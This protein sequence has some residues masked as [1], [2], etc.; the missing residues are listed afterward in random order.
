MFRRFSDLLHAKN[1]ETTRWVSTISAT[2]IFSGTAASLTL[3]AGVLISRTLPLEDV[4]KYGLLLS[5]IQLL[6]LFGA[7]GQPALMT[8]IYSLNPLG[9]F[10]W[11][12]DIKNSFIIELPT[13]LLAIL[14]SVLIYHLTSFQSLFVGSAI[15]LTALIHD[16]VALLNAHR[17]YIW[18]NLLLRI[19]GATTFFPAFLG[20]FI[21]LFA[22]LDVILITI[23][24]AIICM[25]LLSLYLLGKYSSHGEKHIPLRTRL[26][27][28]GLM[29]LIATHFVPF[30]GLT[31]LGG[32]LVPLDQLAAL[33][34]FSIL[35][36]PFNLL[37]EV[38]TQMM[39]VEMARNPKL[40]HQRIAFWL[41]SSAIILGGLAILLLPLITPYLYGNR[42]NTYIDLIFPLAISGALV[43]AEILPR[44][45]LTA[46]AEA[47][48]LNLFV[49]AH[50][51]TAILG[52]G[53][54]ILLGFHAG[55]I[56]IAWAGAIILV[57]R[58]LCGYGF[59]FYTMKTKKILP[60][61][62]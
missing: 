11:A 57:I 38:I 2:T 35:L 41:W 24:L 42:Y 45:Y 3:I 61:P 51:V 6:P 14:G 32:I 60:S 20:L 23:I 22:N 26:L 55:I 44:S 59:Y 9:V 18:A 10:D 17:Q 46:R 58:N 50:L 25:A 28:L 53:I 49:T 7:L 52:V 4:G 62:L 1:T 12:I 40:N 13:L 39:S 48:L 15:L 33:T 37:R 56:G 29:V 43:M 36:R 19:P 54:A 21:P 5:L 34:A 31:V 30:Q 16:A 47:H 8:R 27:G